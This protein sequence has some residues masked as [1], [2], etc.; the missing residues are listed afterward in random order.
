MAMEALRQS[1]DLQ[2]IQNGVR[3]MEAGEGMPIDEAFQKIDGALVAKY[4]Q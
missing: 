3:Q 2:A 1:E 4:G